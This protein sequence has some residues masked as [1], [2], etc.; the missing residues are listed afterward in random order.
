[1]TYMSLNYSGSSRPPLRVLRPVLVSYT[2]SLE[3]LIGIFNRPLNRG[4]VP[5]S[6]FGI[7]SGSLRVGPVLVLPVSI[8]IPLLSLF[9]FVE[10][11]IRGA[12]RPKVDDFIVI[13]RRFI[14]FVRALG[15]R[16]FNVYH[17]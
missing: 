17:I 12:S 15:G 10:G 2:H 1:M 11:E 14:L 13:Y 8:R 9:T 3:P 6:V 16:D 7:E 4:L 5:Q